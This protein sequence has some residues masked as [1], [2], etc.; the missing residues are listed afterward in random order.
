MDTKNTQAKATDNNN[1]NNNGAKSQDKKKSFSEIAKDAQAVSQVLN[2]SAHTGLDIYNAITARSDQQLKPTMD[3]N[4][5]YYE[6]MHAVLI[7]NAKNGKMPWAEYA[8]EKSKLISAQNSEEIRLR[9]AD[10]EIKDLKAT[11]RLKTAGAW[12]AGLTGT[13]FL[14]WGI[15]KIIQ[16]VKLAKKVA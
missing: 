12:G 5:K 15:S 13:G 6:G 4:E 9:K 14:C 2:N 8:A 1:K 3:R 7:A 11:A 10:A 16:V